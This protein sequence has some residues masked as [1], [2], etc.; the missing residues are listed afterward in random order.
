MKRRHD[1]R[2]RRC[3]GVWT[4]R[5]ASNGNGKTVT[6]LYN[7]WSV[8]GTLAYRTYSPPDYCLVVLRSKEPTVRSPSG[9]HLRVPSPPRL[10]STKRC[11]NLSTL[12]DRP[13]LRLSPARCLEVA[14]WRSG[15]SSA[16]WITQ[17]LRPLGNAPRCYYSIFYQNPCR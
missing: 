17:K 6:V 2:R 5:C 9:V 11:R 12:L 14:P 8:Q 16:L 13:G 4:T 15:Y 7:T 10:Y 3:R 1:R